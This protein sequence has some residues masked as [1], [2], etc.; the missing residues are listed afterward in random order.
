MT[1]V[2]E[3]IS[4]SRWRMHRTDM[5]FRW[6]SKCRVGICRN[7]EVL[8]IIPS[9]AVQT[10]LPRKLQCRL[11]IMHPF[12]GWR[13]LERI[14]EPAHQV[15]VHV[16]KT[17]IKFLFIQLDNGCGLDR[18]ELLTASSSYPQEFSS[19]PRLGVNLLPSAAAPKASGD[20]RP[21]SCDVLQN[22]R[23]GRRNFTTG[24]SQNRA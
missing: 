17:S 15:T 6:L 4:G 16:F 12:Q 1:R 23:V 24:P 10:R 2:T 14:V 22:R 20:C 9:G 21:A 11:T 5:S 3:P 18:G 8:T 13:R 7:R 19:P